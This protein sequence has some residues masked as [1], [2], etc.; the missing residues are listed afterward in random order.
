MGSILNFIFEHSE[1][2]INGGKYCQMGQLRH[3]V[4]KNYSFTTNFRLKNGFKNILFYECPNNHMDLLKYV[5]KELSDF[6]ISNDLKI[7][8][9]N[10]ADPTHK[11][12]INSVKDKI[13]KNILS[14]VIFMD[15]NTS[16]KGEYTF[17]Y[18]LEE[19]VKD[20]KY[21]FQ[22][23]KND[24]GYISEQITLKELDNYRNKKF[25]SFNRI[26]TK[27]HRYRLLCDYVK[28]DL[29][30]SYF[31]FIELDKTFKGCKKEINK[32]N[33]FDKF[34]LN[35]IKKT[36]DIV[37]LE[38]DTKNSKDKIGFKTNNTFKKDLFLDSCINIVTETSM[39]YNELFISEKIFKPILSYQPFIVLGPVNYLKRLK[40]YGFKTF[41]NFWDE[42][43]DKIEDS[44]K[45]YDKVLQTI[46]E[47]NK[48][49]IDELN[50]LY[51]SLKEICIYNRNHFVN[52]KINTFDS[53]LKKIENEW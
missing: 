46:L 23:N 6:V 41:D 25:L 40:Y 10:I 38:L 27:Y 18:F 5:E 7:L 4:L 9:A 32:K 2:D 52:L 1:N 44:S 19:G 16:L 39:F 8:V 24:L 34:D 26:V 22:N 51:K 43:Y 47:L 50:N 29:S 36:F 53:T 31:S 21:Y 37:P 28:H 17:D 49:S 14:K 45:R 3:K 20:F 12:I 42:S 48:K 13:N 15:V 30:D 11:D 35:V 33:I